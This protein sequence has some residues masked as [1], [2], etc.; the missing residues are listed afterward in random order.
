MTLDEM[1]TLLNR[2]DGEEFLKFDRV[3]NPRHPCPD[4]CAFLLLNERAPLGPDTD[5]VS[6]AHHDKYYLATDPATFAANASE[7]DVIT[8][9]RCGILYE[10]DVESFASFT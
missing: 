7:A 3:E 4:V 8:L 9:A 1:D 2:N 5:M 10:S 6:S